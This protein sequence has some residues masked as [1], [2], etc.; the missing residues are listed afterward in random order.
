MVRVSK[1]GY[2]YSDR[3]V[4]AVPGLSKPR[5]LLHSLSFLPVL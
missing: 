2:T 3:V 5:S 4:M 1:E